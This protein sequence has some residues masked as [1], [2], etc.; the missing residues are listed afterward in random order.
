MKPVTGLLP[1]RLGARWSLENW[2]NG[3]DEEGHL[4]ALP[5]PATRRPL[6]PMED[7]PRMQ[8]PLSPAMS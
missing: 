2:V 7:P 8:E 1:G 4:P 6:V 3:G 5:P